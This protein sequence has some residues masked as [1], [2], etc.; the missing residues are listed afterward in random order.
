MNILILALLLVFPSLAS[1]ATQK[2]RVQI[3][4]TE[5]TQYGEY[6]DALYFTPEEYLLKTQADLDILKQQR[7]SGYV[8]A[9]KNAPAPVEPTKEELQAQIVSIDEQSA[10]LAVQKV[11]IQAKIDAIKPKVIEVIP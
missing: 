10:S 1:A 2:E 4:F 11:E 7:V 9:I 6:T 8:N 3:L 5:D